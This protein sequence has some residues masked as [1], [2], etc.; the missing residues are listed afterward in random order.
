LILS[1][2]TLYGTAYGG[3][4][5]YGTVFSI[6]T[7]GLGFTTLYSFTNGSDGAHPYAGLLLS[8]GTLYGTAYGGGSGYGTVFS[9]GTNGMGFTTVHTFTGGIGGGNPY[10]GL[11]LSGTT[12]YGTGES[13]GSM[14]FG[15]VF[16]VAPNGTGFTNLLSFDNL[17]DGFYPYAGLTLA[18]N[19]LYGTVPSGGNPGSGTVYSLPQTVL[20]EQAILI[21]LTS[22]SLSLPVSQWTPLATNIMT[23]TNPVQFYILKIIP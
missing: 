15:T 14:S 23:V 9:V 8:G 16:A 19:T 17:T 2:S 10:A 6:G 21:T 1:G 4:S 7:N 22:T 13:G 3:G 18:G 11:I 5:G 12:L 20:Q